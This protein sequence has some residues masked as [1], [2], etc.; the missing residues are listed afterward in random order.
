MNFR[1]SEFVTGALLE[2]GYRKA[3]SAND[4]DVILFNSCSVRKHAEDRLFSNIA[5]LKDLKRKKSG[6][7]IGLIGCTAQNYGSSVL[8]R[9][10][11]VDFVCGPGNLTELPNILRDVLKNRCPVVACDKVNDKRSELFP[12]Y[13]NGS[14]KAYVSISEG[15]NNFCSYCIVPYVRG[16]ERSRDSKDIIKEV[17]DLARRGFKE[18]TLLGQN[19]NSYGKVTSNKLQVTSFV[20]LLEKLNVIKGIKRIRFMTSHP[21]DA[22]QDLF[23]AMRDLENV[24]EH[25]HLPLQSGSDR[26]LKLMNR[27]Y[28]AK[29]Y[30]K[31]AEGYKMFVPGGSITTDIIVGFPSE[32]GRDFKKTADLMKK[33]GFDSAFT[34]KYS[35]RPPARSSGLKDDVADEEKGKR[36]NALMDLQA[37]ISEKCNIP[38][39]GEIVRILVDGRNKKEPSMLSGRT[40]ANKIAIFR[41]DKRLIGRFVNVKIESITPYALKGRI[42]K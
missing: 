14:F 39:R 33:V 13:R 36:L 16:R 7:V 19:V 27:G 20:K 15:C 1:D 10:P 38:M 4:A 21:K 28:T 11:L 6:L 5:T 24:C 25:L 37:K 32:T 35:A 30:L 40:R 41:G 18:I 12:E 22:S 29:K 31:L 9:A 8:E 42:V 34:F 2:E 23:K 26:I 17:R 3:G